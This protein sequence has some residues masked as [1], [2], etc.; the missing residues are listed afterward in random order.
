MALNSEAGGQLL[1]SFEMSAVVQIQIHIHIYMHVCVVCMYET[2]TKEGR[3]TGKLSLE[4]LLQKRKLY[5]VE[6]LE[7][8]CWHNRLLVRIDRVLVCPAAGVSW[9]L[10][11][12]LIA[13]PAAVCTPARREARV[14]RDYGA[15]L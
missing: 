10:S 12:P 7:D 8:V 2:R 3:Q 1:V 4:R 15:V 9:F 5:V 14:E 6:G 13:S 11:L